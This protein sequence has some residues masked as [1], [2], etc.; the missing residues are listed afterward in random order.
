MWIN[1]LF[2]EHGHNFIIGTIYIFRHGDENDEVKWEK[3]L[4]WKNYIYIL[5]G[6]IYI[7]YLAQ[8]SFT[9]LYFHVQVL[10]DVPYSCSLLHTFF[11]FTI[12]LKTNVFIIFFFWDIC[13]DMMALEDKKYD[14]YLFLL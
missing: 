2:G 6:K 9:L 5:T 4:G 13:S 1:V 3:T 10:H 12:T 11:Q 7:F 8:F 14:I